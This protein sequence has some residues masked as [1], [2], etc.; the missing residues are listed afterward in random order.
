ML[1]ESKAKQK[2]IVLM[3][4]GQPTYS[5]RANSAKSYSWPDNKYD[6]IL[7]NFNYNSRLG[8]GNDYELPTGFLGFGDYRY[9]V[10]GFSVEVNCIATL[11][12]ETH[13]MESV[14]VTYIH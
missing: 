4:D 6:F 10:N 14:I 13:Y 5:F 1:I 3:S 8:S 9:Y 11:S 7:S 2:T 12:E